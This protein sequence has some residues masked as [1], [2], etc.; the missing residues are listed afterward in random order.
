[1]AG[2][3]KVGTLFHTPIKKDTELNLF[4]AECIGVWCSAPLP[5]LYRRSKHFLLVLFRQVNLQKRNVEVCRHSHR[6]N[7]V[8]R[9]RTR[10]ARQCNSYKYAGY[11]VTFV[12]Q[13]SRRHGGI[14]A[15]GEAYKNFSVLH[16]RLL[17]SRSG[18][19]SCC[20]GGGG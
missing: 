5:L 10:V 13:Q 9:G 20:G 6:L 4:I 15:S 14:N 2:C 16:G 7:P 12:L 1:M 8:F 3:N 18:C 11:I 19:S 17:R